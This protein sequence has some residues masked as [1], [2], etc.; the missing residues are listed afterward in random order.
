MKIIVGLGNPEEK[1]KTTYHNLGFI[2]VED[3]AIAFNVKFKKIQCKALIAE[4]NYNGEKIIIAK[5]QTYMNLS[6]ESV[7]ELLGYYKASPEDLIVIYDDYDL[8]LGSIRI[9]KEGS[10]GTHNGMRNIIDCIKTTAFTRIRIGFNDGSNIP[11]LN[12]VLSNIPKEYYEIFAET[13][14]SGA[15]AAVDIAKGVDFETIGRRYNKTVKK[16]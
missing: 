4:A 3:V 7:R 5:P 14:K 13:V 8:P 11:L 12:H 1:Y 16:G 6:G 10:A 2:A 15:N 9:R